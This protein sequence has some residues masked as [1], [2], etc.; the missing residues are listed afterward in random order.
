MHRYYVVWKAKIVEQRE[1]KHFDN[2]FLG[3][4]IFGLNGEEGSVKINMC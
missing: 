2:I 3:V 4:N 1:N